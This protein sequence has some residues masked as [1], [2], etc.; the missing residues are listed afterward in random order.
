MGTALLFPGQGSQAV[1]MLDA[2]LVE[3]AARRAEL[4]RAEAVLGLPLRRLMTAGPAAE[5]DRTEVAQPALL[6]VGV[7]HARHLRQLGVVPR[8]LLGHSL[9]HVTALVVAGA[10][11]FELALRLVAL[12]ARILVEA[13]PPEGGAMVAVLGVAR[14]RVYAACRARVGRGVVGVACHNAPGQTVISGSRPAVEAVADALDAEGA[15][16]SQLNIPLGAHSDLLRPVVPYFESIVAEAEVAD[17]HTT[18]LDS[19]TARPLETAADVRRSLVQQLTAP[20]LFEEGVRA[21][22]ALGVDTFV[23]CGPGDVL[24][25]C[26]RR[27]VPGAAV[28]TFR[29]AGH[30]ARPLVPPA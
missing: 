17:P 20:I 30:R 11:G 9:G 12:H 23:E 16:T 15:L 27:Q 18:V 19:V 10:V 5:L 4:E 21:A 8:C 22:R 14:E 7:L 1:G 24:T 3:E 26:V 6:T 13:M 25:R 29:E 28:L 2:F